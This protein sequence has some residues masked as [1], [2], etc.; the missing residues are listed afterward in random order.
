MGLDGRQRGTNPKKKLN[1]PEAQCE[2]HFGKKAVL[3]LKMIAI[4]QEAKRG[5]PRKPAASAK[6][7]TAGWWVRLFF[8]K[9]RRSGAKAKKHAVPPLAFC[10]S[11]F[12]EVS[13]YYYYY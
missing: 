6:R 4:W 9:P 3:S 8:A 13:L 12:S 11:A 5:A 1:T 2:R 7:G 10:Q